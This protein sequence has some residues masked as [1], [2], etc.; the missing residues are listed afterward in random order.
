MRPEVVLDEGRGP[1]ASRSDSHHSSPSSS[2]S[3]TTRV[4][5]LGCS[6][7]QGGVGLRND[8]DRRCSWL[9]FCG[10]WPCLAVRMIAVEAASPSAWIVSAIRCRALLT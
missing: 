4:G 7:V 8:L 10:D 5:L 1:P 6:A 3:W 9:L 2:A